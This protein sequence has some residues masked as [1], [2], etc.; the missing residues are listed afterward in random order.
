MRSL[1]A[2]QASSLASAMHANTAY[3]AAGLA[4]A[5]TTVTAT[6]TTPTISDATLATA[7][8]CTSASGGAQPYCTPA[9]MAAY[10]LQQWATAS[11]ALLPNYQATINCSTVVGVPVTCTIQLTWA[12]K[13]MAVNSQSMNGP[14]MQAPTYTLYVQP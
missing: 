3:W 14:A 10:D 6:T 7:A 11:A 4:P 12:E 2:I 5:S 9:A 1:A 13:S 8:D